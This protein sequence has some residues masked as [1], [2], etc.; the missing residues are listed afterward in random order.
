MAIPAVVIASE[1]AEAV[2]ESSWVSVKEGL[3]LDRITLGSSS[4]SPR[5][6]QSA[7]AIVADFANA[8]LTFWND[9]GVVISLGSFFSAVAIAV[10]TSSAAPS[11]K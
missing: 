7:A 10:W 4:V 3:L 11:M 2:G 1:H 9:G 5:H 6:V 8:G